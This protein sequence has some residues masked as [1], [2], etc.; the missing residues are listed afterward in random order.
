MSG[1]H[2]EI[3]TEPESTVREVLKNAASY[4]GKKPDDLVLRKGGVVLRGP[5]TIIEA[6][7]E[8]GDIVELIP[9][10]ELSRPVLVLDAGGGRT[11]VVDRPVILGR[12]HLR[13]FLVKAD[14]EARISR[15]Q[16]SIWYRKGI[17]AVEDGARGHASRNGTMLNDQDL[18]G[19]DRT[20]IRD[21]DVLEIA[22][23]LRLTLRVVS[24]G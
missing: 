5:E 2:V 3:E 9:L 1:A 10:E 19:R 12:K 13:A 23:I 6:G 8:E 4:W 15:R 22:G 11:L 17:Y 18:R 16:M 20:P 14:D 21:G 24:Q 7:I